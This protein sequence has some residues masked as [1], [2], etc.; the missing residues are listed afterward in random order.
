MEDFAKELSSIK[1]ALDAIEMGLMMNAEAIET[2]EMDIRFLQIE[3]DNE[4]LNKD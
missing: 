4:V 1:K 2:L 3:L